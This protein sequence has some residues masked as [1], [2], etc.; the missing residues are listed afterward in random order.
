M[1]RQST[2]GWWQT[3]FFASRVSTRSRLRVPLT[4]CYDC[5]TTGA[6]WRGAQVIAHDGPDVIVKVQAEASYIRTLHV[7]REMFDDADVSC[8]IGSP[9]ACRVEGP[10]V[11]QLVVVEARGGRHDPPPSDEAGMVRAGLF[12]PSVLNGLGIPGGP[13]VYVDE[14]GTPWNAEPAPDPDDDD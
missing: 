5:S 1:G 8:A 11:D 6:R 10:G 12:Q 2:G 7:P 4:H 9:I 14:V 13:A 3:A